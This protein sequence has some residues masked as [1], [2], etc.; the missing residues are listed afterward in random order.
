[1][2]QFEANRISPA[3]AALVAEL[4]RVSADLRLAPPTQKPD[5]KPAE[6]PMT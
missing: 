1:M 6:K 4:N 2:E 3:M 5:E